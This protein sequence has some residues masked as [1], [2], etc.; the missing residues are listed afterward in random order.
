MGLILVIDNGIGTSL[1]YLQRLH[2]TRLRFNTI[3]PI[4]ITYSHAL[5]M[6]LLA[7]GKTNRQ[8][9]VDNLV[10]TTSV[11]SLAVSEMIDEISPM[12]NSTSTT[13]SNTNTGVRTMR[14]NTSV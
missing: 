1:I 5:I 7:S 12:E 4:L 13:S 9:E 14:W 2:N 10:E 11:G 3:N 8:R 6:D